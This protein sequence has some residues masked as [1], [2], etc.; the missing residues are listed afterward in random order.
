MENDEPHA[1]E[2]ALLHALGELVGNLVVGDVTPPDDDV[3]LVEHGIG[4][5]VVGLVERCRSHH[6]A[7]SQYGAQ[8]V[9]DHGVDAVGVELGR[10]TALA[11]LHVFV[12]DH[13]V[14]ATLR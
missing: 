7:R 13:D 11:L 2:H 10:D 14:Q 3:R 12:P 9:G 6:C 1:L 4:Q 5:A 8:A